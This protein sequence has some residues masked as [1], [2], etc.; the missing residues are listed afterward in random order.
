MAESGDMGV[1]WTIG[2][3]RVWGHGDVP[4]CWGRQRVGKWGC[5]GLSEM[6]ESRDLGIFFPGKGQKSQELISNK[7]VTY[8]FTVFSVANLPIEKIYDLGKV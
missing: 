1:Y 4:V 8:F 6:A 2:N 3:G 7:F 5:P